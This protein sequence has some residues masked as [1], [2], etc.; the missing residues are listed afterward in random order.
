VLKRDFDLVAVHAAPIR[1]RIQTQ[2]IRALYRSRRTPALVVADKAS[3]GQ[4]DGLN[5]GLV[6][7]PG[8]LACAIDADT[9]V[10]PDAL[11]RMIRPF[12]LDDDVIAAGGTL[13]VVNGS[14]VRAGRVIRERA[15]RRFLPGVQAVEYLRAF[16]AGRVGWNRLGRH[17]DI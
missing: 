13:R 3:G 12:L 7:A 11:Q 6:V 17:L 9:I 5:A 2:P 1:R 14:E 10:E 8:E 16:L 4:A 15:P